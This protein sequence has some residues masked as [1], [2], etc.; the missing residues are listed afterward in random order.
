MK[1]KV[2]PRSQVAARP[3]IIARRFPRRIDSSAQWT[4]KLDEMRIA[5]LT[6]ATPTGRRRPLGGHGPEFATT[7]MKKEEAKNAPK[8]ITSETMKRRIP[9]VWR[10]I[11]ELACA[12]GGP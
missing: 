11:R 9:S 10:S 8:S 6:P 2:K 3:M 1:R 7:L 5:V 4:V 12:S